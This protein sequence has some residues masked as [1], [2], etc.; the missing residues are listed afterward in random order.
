MSVTRSHQ[1]LYESEE[2]GKKNPEL[3]V[4]CLFFFCQ[5]LKL[6]LEFTHLWSVTVFKFLSDDKI[7]SYN[8]N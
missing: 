7:A 5:L 4:N 3:L 6:R 1:A 8:Q 2:K